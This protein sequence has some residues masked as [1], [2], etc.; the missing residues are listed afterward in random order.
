MMDPLDVLK[1]IDPEEL[2]QPLPESKWRR[3]MIIAVGIF[4]VVLMFSLSFS[5]SL[6]GIIQSS[7]IKQQQ[8]LFSNTTIVFTDD[9]LNLLQEEYLANQEREIKACLFGERQGARYSIERIEF[10]EVRSASV[11]HISSSGCPIE[12]LIDLHSHPINSCIA[13]SQDVSNYMRLTRKR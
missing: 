1:D 2:E 13:S 10:P 3:P 8:L 5:G 7:T 6:M 9:T 11:V 12:T 4:L